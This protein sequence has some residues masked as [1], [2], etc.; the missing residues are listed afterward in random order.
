MLTSTA[1]EIARIVEVV[2]E[3]IAVV[4]EATGVQR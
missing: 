4:A 2:A 3:S 1:A